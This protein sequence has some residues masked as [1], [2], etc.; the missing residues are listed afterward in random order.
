MEGAT[1]VTTYSI[2]RATLIAAAVLASPLRADPGHAPTPQSASAKPARPTL[3]LRG[4]QWFDGAGFGPAHWFVVDGKFTAT[5]PARVDAVVDLGQ[6]YVLPPLAEAHNHN[7]QNPWGAATFAQDYLRRGIFYSAQM[8]ANSEEIAPFRGLLGTPGMPDVLFAEVTISTSDG[9]PL[10]LA[11]DGAKAAGM[12]L[13][14]D[15]VRDKAYVS[16][17]S[18]ADLDARWD[19]VK[20]TEAKLIKVILVESERYAQHHKAADRF[21]VNGVDPALLPEI[22]RRAHAMGARV[23]VHADTAHDAKVAVA[24]G[25]DII[26]HLP[27]YRIDAPLTVKDYR[28]DDA[29]FAEA[30]RRG[31]QW[32]GTVA[33]A[34][35]F[36]R[37]NPDRA[38]AVTASY[39]DNVIRMRAAGVSLLTGSDVFEGSV[40]DELVALDA[41]KAM[42]RTEVL[43]SATMT[44]PLAL[45][46]ARRIGCLC[47]GAEASLIA[48]EGN[49]LVDLG[50]LREVALALKQGALLSL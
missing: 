43:R 27:G 21:G 12:A 34:R 18:L 35:Y 29:T 16:V 36:L 5:R 46:P 1:P 41:L 50:A 7:L 37:K 15:D 24:A 2:I 6:R 11:L 13:A 32:I 4:G 8:A 3:E 17:D 26:A 33:A 10:R 47:E 38:A 44:T 23:A 14:A 31:T 40:V 22:V 48:L 25:A 9:H 30:A 28:I 49:P 42:P 19:R 45:F 39:R 20:A